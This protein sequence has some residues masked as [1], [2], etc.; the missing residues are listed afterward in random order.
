[1]NLPHRFK[2]L[3]AMLFLMTLASACEG[4]RAYPPPVVY[5]YVSPVSTYL[6]D[7]PSYECGIIANVYS[8]DRV[9]LLD[10]NDYGWSQVR[11]TRSGQVGW[12][13]GDLLSLAPM[14][15]NFYV[16]A[17][18]VYL[19]ECADY[20]C[21]ALELLYRGDRVEKIDQNNLGWWRVVSSK[22]RTQG[23]VPVVAVSPSPGPPFYYV[24]VSSLALRANPS[25][26]SRIITNL[27]FNSQVEMLGMGPAGWANVREVRT[28]TIGWVSSY[29]LET[30]PVSQARPAPKR[31]APAKKAAPEEEEAPKRAPKAM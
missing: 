21:R 26:S 3:M 2:G 20:N 13:P 17:A 1:M 12:I 11:L 5:Y 19:R 24:A 15:A 10:R 31:K 8:G 4:P 18:T 22:S 6:R 23:W 7:C 16:A 27:G 30:F 28:G 25:T 29:Y 14:P 9:E